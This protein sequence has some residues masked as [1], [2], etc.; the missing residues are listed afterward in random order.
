MCNIYFKIS[1]H[2]VAVGGA[3]M[4]FLLFSF[5]DD[6][7][8]GLYPSLALLVTGLVCTARLLTGAHT[9]FQIGS[10]LFIGLLAQY[11]AWQF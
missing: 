4:F 10:G 9:P 8:S 3:L 6:Y 1:M 5:N 11:I 7:G 2:T